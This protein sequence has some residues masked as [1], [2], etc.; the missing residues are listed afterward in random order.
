MIESNMADKPETFAYLSP[1][2]MDNIIYKVHMYAPHSF[3]HQRLAGEG[4][5]VTYPGRI[6]GEMWDRERIRRELKPV[7][8]FQKRHNCKIYVGEFSAIAWAPGAEKYLND[9]IEVF[10]ELG[11]DWSYHA[12]REWNGWSLEHEG[13]NPQ[14][15][16]PGRNDSAPGGFAEIFQ[17]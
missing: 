2:A 6:D 12:F 1:L 14:T 11:W 15:M 17:A 4:P 16:K 5:V 13:D 8:E 9:C 3:T 10:E 7:I